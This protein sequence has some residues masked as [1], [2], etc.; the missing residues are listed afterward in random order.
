MNAPVFAKRTLIRIA[1]VLVLLLA[2][3]TA[4]VRQADVLLGKALTGAFG[5]R[6]VTYRSV[7]FDARGNVTARNVSVRPDDLRE[8]QLAFDRVWLETPG[9]GFFL[10]HAFDRELQHAPW[11]KLRLVFADLERSDGLEVL[12]PEFGPVGPASGAMLET[13]G[14]SVSR[15]FTTENLREM[16]LSPGI[17]TLELE[18]R[19]DG[20]AAYRMLALET[21]GSS[22]TQL[23]RHGRLARPRTSLLDTR[24]EARVDSERWRV[25]DQGFVPARNRFCA[26]MLGIAARE[27]PERHI[28]AIDELLQHIGLAVDENA[29]A[30]YRRFARSGGEISFG[31]EYALPLVP[32]E[33]LGDRD[34]GRAL[35]RM[36]A[37]LERDTRAVPVAWRSV[38]MPALPNAG[39]TA[40]VPIAPPKTVAPVTVVR[41]EVPAQAPKPESEPA[42]A[43]SSQAEIPGPDLAKTQPVP[44]QAPAREPSKPEPSTPAQQAPSIAAPVIETASSTPPRS[45]SNGLRIVEH[46]APATRRA[47]LGWDELARHQGR[48]IRLWTVHNPPR[49]VEVL[50][51]RGDSARVRARLGGGQAEYTVQRSG[52]LKAQPIP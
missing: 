21:P 41:V 26:A 22:R 25:R 27:L 17:T 34:D 23:E 13:A 43:E 48:R 4:A 3:A 46:A 39:V 44:V 51:V 15:A 35:A 49:T 6:Q 32:D 2:A 20:E 50:S 38:A 11:P 40:N 47:A 12:L 42:Q 33:A 19:V 37:S 45:A 24:L 36:S 52:F 18:Q 31:G 5:T 10:R 28:A 9:W 29:R 1:L 30:F 7:W 14:C 16:K 8:A